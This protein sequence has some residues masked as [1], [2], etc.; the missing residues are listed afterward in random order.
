MK[1]THGGETFFV[2][3]KR[4]SLCGPQG[5]RVDLRLQGAAIDRI[6][7]PDADKSIKNL[8]LPSMR[9]DDYAGATLGPAAGRLAGAQLPIDGRLLSLGANDGTNTLHGGF[10]N[11]SLRQWT[12]AGSGNGS[13]AAWAELKCTLPHGLDGF[14]GH[15]RFAVRYTLTGDALT[16]RYTAETDRPTLISMSNHTYWN[17]TGDFSADCYDQ[18]LEI[19]ASE[20]LYN[21]AAHLPHALRPCG[22]TAFDFSSPVSL[23]AAM[24]RA[25]ERSS[26]PL[27]SDGGQLQNAR[28]YNNGFS[29]SPGAPFAARLTAPRGGLRMTLTTDQPYLVVYSGG[30]L[31]TPGCA[32]ALEAQGKPGAVTPLL[33]PGKTYHRFIRFAFDY[34]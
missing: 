31:P 20:V 24:A 11:L 2:D 21:D 18:L 3:F 19:R 32:L 34:I 13:S 1:K 12:L 33:Q 22:G 8:A 6:F 10:H 28:G 16:L 15:R 27:Y 25:E 23:R 30:Y 17:L 29:L 5:R 4:L 14:P 26:A 7:W 9:E